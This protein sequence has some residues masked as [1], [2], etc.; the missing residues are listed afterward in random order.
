MCYPKN[1]EYKFKEV[2][3]DDNNNNT[4]KEY[5]PD[6]ALSESVSCTNW[7]R[8]KAGSLTVVSYASL[9]TGVVCIVA[10][11]FTGGASLGVYAGYA[12]TLAGWVSVGCIF[13]GAAA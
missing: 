12:A 4:E 10:V 8:F 1:G 3:S 11:P 6:L 9:V 2:E 5:A 13:I 7:E